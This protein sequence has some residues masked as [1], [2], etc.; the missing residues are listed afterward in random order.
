MQE[1]K[2]GQFYDD[3]YDNINHIWNCKIIKFLDVNIGKHCCNLGLKQNS[4]TW[5]QTHDL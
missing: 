2:P 1:S 5:H 4:Y 3:I